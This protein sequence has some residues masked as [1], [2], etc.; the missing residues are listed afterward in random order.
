MM[1]VAY[2]QKY[3]ERKQKVLALLKETSRYYRN[4]GDEERDRAFIQLYENVEKGDF[5]IVVVGEFSSGKSTLLNALMREKYLPS[6]TNETTAT[7]NFLKHTAKAPGQ[8]SMYVY[9]QNSDKAPITADATL[10]NI[11]D[12]VSTRSTLSVA[13]EVERVELYLDSRFLEAGVS[14]V[15]SPGLNGVAEGHMDIT[16]RQIEKSHACIFVFSAE[17]PGRNSDFSFLR[18]LHNK[19]DTILL[20]LNKIDVVKKDEQTVEEVVEKLKS[21]YHTQFPNETMPEI[22]PVAAYPALVAR[23]GREL[24]YRGKKAHGEEEKNNYLINSR[25][26]QFEE[27]LWRFLTC[28]E[29][30]KE[31][32]LAP[33]KRIKK[34]LSER[35]REVQA[36]MKNLQE[37]KDTSG[38]RELIAELEQETEKL[39]QSLDE[40]RRDISRVVD[41]AISGLRMDIEAER[42]RIYSKFSKEVEDWDSTRD[43]ETMIKVFQKRVTGGYGSSIKRLFGRFYDQLQGEVERECN[44]R[45]CELDGK[46][47]GISDIEVLSDRKV[48]ME[49]LVV[50]FGLEEYEERVNN[51]QQ[52]LDDLESELIKCQGDRLKAV[53]VEQQ[54]ELLRAKIDSIE[55]RRENYV[56]IFQK[57]QAIIYH[58]DE[59]SERDRRGILGKLAQ[60][61]VGK[62]DE[63]RQ[64]RRVDNSAV[65]EFEKEKERK[66]DDFNR[67]EA[68]IAAE[69]ATI[70]QTESS[71]AYNLKLQQL[72]SLKRR[73]NSE[74]EKL[75]LRHKEEFQEE[76]RVYLNQVKRALS[77]YLT[78]IE[79]DID[80]LVKTELRNKRK[81]ITGI[82][83]D[84]VHANLLKII[85]KKQ[86]RLE[87]FRQQLAS[88]LEEKNVLLA[89]Y[90]QEKKENQNLLEQAV[91]LELELDMVQV[92]TVANL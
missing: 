25:L 61:L 63:I 66:M 82:I 24:D 86:V 2:R 22:W 58:E 69:L 53:E 57:P 68:G 91:S 23:S 28:G 5:S 46:L 64:V 37:A 72:E 41:Q 35:S 21:N 73:K 52:T 48:D 75:R 79:Q 51:M 88:S 45:L 62:K 71:Q 39:E 70:D 17:Q 30:T 33:V 89:E 27:R 26:E 43:L 11:E 20:V 44:E 78:A 40:K 49:E 18:D 13:E 50:S 36:K 55:Q 8:H 12:F 32:L 7:V 15:D 14:L 65:E 81:I 34:L 54:V 76:Y 6:Y 84:M 60:V 87:Q 83:V 67:Q 90:E 31:E 92:D 56:A 16:E 10:E 4:I 80:D 1:G 59:R 19:V 38:V 77:D 9:F 74:L 47:Q 29:K 3:E 42:T 85:D